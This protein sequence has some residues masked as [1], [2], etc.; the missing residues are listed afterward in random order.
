MNRHLQTI[1]CDDIR[2]EVGGKYSY[3]GVYGSRLLISTL[4]ATLPKL[5]LALKVVTP[6]IQPFRK[7]SLE[8]L[9]DDEVIAQWPLDEAPLAEASEAVVKTLVDDVPQEQAQIVNAIFV[10]SPFHIEGPCV[11]RVR[12]ETESEKL[13][14]LVLRIEQAQRSPASNTER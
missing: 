13:R 5:C 11:L 9:R 2:Q 12:A 8:V 4:P 3:I 6:V 10:F 14:G 7:L 1:F